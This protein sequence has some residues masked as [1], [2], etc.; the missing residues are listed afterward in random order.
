VAAIEDVIEDADINVE[1][2]GHDIK[3]FL[4]EGGSKKQIFS[5][6]QRDMYRKYNWPA[7]PKLHK[8]LQELQK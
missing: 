2:A 1:E 4:I 8:V 7:R 5:C 3:V 6:P